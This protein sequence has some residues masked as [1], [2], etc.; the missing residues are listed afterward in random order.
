[1]QK[2]RK[3]IDKCTSA[4]VMISGIVFVAIILLVLVSIIKRALFGAPIRGTVEIVQFGVMFC[5]AAALPKTT[6]LERH[7]RVTM[8]IDAMPAT[9]RKIINIFV[10]LAGLGVFGLLVYRLF[11]EVQ[12]AAAKHRVT[13]I[14]KIP[15]SFVYGV[16]LV[17][18]TITALVVL[19]QMIYSAV[20]TL[21]K[22]GLKPA[23]DA[24]GQDGQTAE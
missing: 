7:T 20:G 18:V 17:S 11:I 10:K 13:E 19:Y 16:L 23:C 24:S 5:I 22:D 8:L 4:L 15:F 1:M 2:V 14:F 21:K 9:A 3:M 6:L 12:N